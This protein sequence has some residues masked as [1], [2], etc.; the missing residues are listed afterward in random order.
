MEKNRKKKETIAICI[1]MVAAYLV[2]SLIFKLNT[3]KMYEIEDISLLLKTDVKILFITMILMCFTYEGISIIEPLVFY[4]TVAWILI[5]THDYYLRGY[6]YPTKEVLIFLMTASMSWVIAN[7]FKFIKSNKHLLLIGLAAITLNGV[8]IYNI[9][10]SFFYAALF[11]G[12]MLVGWNICNLTSDRSHKI[13]SSCASVLGG[14]GIFFGTILMEEKE[15][16]LI[17]WLNPTAEKNLIYSW[18]HLALSQHSLKM[19]EDLPFSRQWVHPFIS[20]N[21]YLGTGAVILLILVFVV[22]TIAFIRSHKILSENRFRLF[23]FLYTLFAVIYVYQFLADLGFVPTAG[24]VIFFYSATYILAVGIIIRLFITRPIFKKT[25]LEYV[26]EFIF[27]VL[28]MDDDFDSDD[29]FDFDLDDDFDY[30]LDDDEDY[31]LDGDN[32][33]DDSDFRFSDQIILRY[34]RAQEREMKLINQKL[35]QLLEQAEK[36][37]SDENNHDIE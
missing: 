30:D 6:L 33:S 15:K 4:G 32:K 24:N 29:D 37:T 14:V 22:V 3:I 23:T 16:S 27:K 34:L 20:T 36:E 19:P 35:D 12:S 7:S 8:V 18:E 9:Q 13:L 11:A 28:E 10:D 17:A 21:Y 26:I 1:S 5:E 25:I 2:L 31:D